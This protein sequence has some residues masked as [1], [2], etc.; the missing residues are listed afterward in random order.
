[1]PYSDFDVVIL[2][3]DLPKYNLKAGTEGVIVDLTNPEKGVYL[4]QF[5]EEDEPLESVFVVSHQIRPA[6]PK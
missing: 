1:M 6:D 3:E 5:F 2:T 4:V